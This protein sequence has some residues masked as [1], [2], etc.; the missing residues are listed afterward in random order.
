[1]R[2]SPD[3]ARLTPPY[4]DNLSHRCKFTDLADPVRGRALLERLKTI[5]TD[6]QALNPARHAAKVTR[7]IAANLAELSKSLEKSGH[8]PEAVAHFLMRILFTLFAE[9]VHLIPNNSFTKLLEDLK[10]TPAK[11]APR[12]QAVWQNMDFPYSLTAG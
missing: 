8:H 5:W 9:D 12:A 11:F 10:D 7:Q 4:P 6:P 1:M 2:T 3:W